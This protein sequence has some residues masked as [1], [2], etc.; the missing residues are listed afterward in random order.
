MRRADPADR[1]RLVAIGGDRPGDRDTPCR[2]WSRSGR[3]GSTSGPAARR[4]AAAAAGAIGKTSPAKSTSR[5]AGK[6]GRS[7]PPCSASSARIDGAE[8]QTLIRRSARKSPSR[9]GSLPSASP[10]RTRVAALRQEA[11]RSKTERSKCRGACEAKRSSADQGPSARWHQSRNVRALACESITPLGWPV[12]PGGEEDVGQVVLGARGRQGRR[13]VVGHDLGPG[14]IAGDDRAGGRDRRRGLAADQDQPGQG[15]AAG[16]RRAQGRGQL[17]GDDR[18][19]DARRGQDRGGTRRRARSGRRARRPRRRGG[20]R[21]SPSPPPGPWAARGPRDRRGRRPSATA[22][23]PPG[24]RPAA[25]RRYVS[26]SPR[27]SS[28]AG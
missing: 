22:A 8:Y 21:G 19:L 5:G 27:S 25:A 16:P 17:G 18:R 13:G 14:R 26:V 10:I 7:R 28:T 6:P 20:C 9:P 4:P 11:N 24:R 12:E 3:R 23:S 2:R 15:A 1:E